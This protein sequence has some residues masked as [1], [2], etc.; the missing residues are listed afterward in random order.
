MEHISLSP[1]PEP[2]PTKM[3]GTEYVIKRNKNE[4]GEFITEPINPQKI[5]RRLQRLKN[6][7]EKFLGRKMNVSVWRISQAVIGQ[8]YDGITTSELDEE[9]AEVAAYITDHPDYADFAGQILVSNLEKNNRDCLGFLAYAEKAFSFIEDRSQKNMPL[10]SQEI[11]DIARKAGHLIDRRMHMDRNYMYDYFAF[12]TLSKGQYLLQTYKIVKR[13]GTEKRMLI[14]FETP[15][16]MWMR[17]A[18]G[19]HR[20]NLEAAFELY[21]TM[22][23]HYG[24]MATPTLFN[25]GTPHPQNSSCF[26]IAMKSDSIPG[27]YDTLKQCAQISKH[28]GGIGLH[29]HDIRAAG[30]Y[31][32]GTN[33]TSNGLV[34]MLRVFNNTARYV[35]QGGGKRKGSFAIYLEPWHADIFEFLDLKR[36][37]GAEDMRARDLFYALWIPDLFWE[38]V[39]T[40]YGRT[41]EEEEKEPTLWSLMCPH[42]CPGLADAYGKKFNELYEKYEAAKKYT[43]QVPIKTLMTTIMSSHIET[44]TP[45]M[46][47]KDH[48]NRKSNQKNLGTIKSSNLCVSGDTFILTKEHGQ[49]PIKDVVNKELHVW[50]GEQWSKTT[51]KQ[52]SDASELWKVELSNGSEIYCTGY[53]KFF[54]QKGPSDSRRPQSI[55]KIEAQELERGMRIPRFQ[56]PQNNDVAVDPEHECKYPYTQ[57]LFAAEGTY[58]LSGK[59]TMALY[60]GKMKLLPY[61]QVRST[62]GTPTKQ[63]LINTTLHYDMHPKYFVPMNASLKTKL[64]WLTGFLDGD[65]T[66]INQVEPPNSTAISIQA[67]SV[68]KAFLVQIRYMLQTMG[69]QSTIQPGR[70]GGKR[71]LPDGKGG[72]KEY[73]CKL[74]WRMI[75]S[76]PGVWRLK[77]LGLQPKRLNI[78]KLDKCSKGMS[79]FVTILSS[80]KT[81]RAEPTYCFTE[82]L[83]NAGIFNGNILG[84]CAEIAEYSSSDECAICNLSSI[85]LPAFVDAKTREF[86]YQRLF[87]VAR[88]FARATNA[89][90]DVNYYPVP[91]AKRS[92]MRHRPIGLGVQGLADTFLK[93]RLPFGSEA[94][95]EVNRNIFET[96]YFAAITES[97]ALTQVIDPETQEITGPYPSI[98]ENGGA[99]IRHGVFQFD[100]WQDD[101][102]NTENPDGWKPNP[103]LGWDWEDLRKKVM[104]DGVRNSLS[105]ALMPTA[106]TSQILKNVESFEPYYSLMFTRKTKNGE[107]FMYCRQLIEDLIERGLWTTELHPLT[108]KSYIPMKEKL[109]E[110][111]GC[112]QNIEEIPQDL[113]DLYVNV[114][115]IKLKDLTDMARDRGVFVDQSMSLNVHMK[116]KDNMMPDLLQYFAYAWQIGLKTASYYIRTQQK[117]DALKFTRIAKADPD[118]VSCSA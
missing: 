8:I 111:Q 35:D 85:S 77:Q 88:I 89:V 9:A 81:N 53:H 44:G 110:A 87:K 18:L 19:I 84:N 11:M 115:D 3:E 34:P 43:R 64:E 12:Q 72:K 52:T 94:S 82:P 22:S 33:G 95:K 65:G 69:V 46:L 117:M 29:I 6:D 25:S 76:S 59:P 100:M 37:H 80:E 57:G 55:V 58:Q 103:K 26:L 102:K 17:V 2:L 32:Q 54:I 116:N 7:A 71:K 96:L 67:T 23:L 79:R 45:Y 61:L 1:S 99:P 113:K 10:I 38:R 4:H 24:T 68:D 114:F 98:D 50:N 40:A 92:N 106:S 47:N 62:T 83:R 41:D 107:F 101:F 42:Q 91:E 70:L 108:K 105:V 118:C 36:P 56:L 109:K 73:D 78:D 14:P 63:N 104:K 31:I 51:V 75:V 5:T 21:D 27:I 93:M 86:D 20:W 48:C 16:H 112:I 97:H 15:Q 74:L 49:V 13:K 60:H 90:I 39:I 30:S 28:A 66:V